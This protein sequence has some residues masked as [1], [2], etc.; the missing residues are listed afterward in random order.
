MDEY[1]NYVDKESNP[2]I[3][4]QARPIENSWG[5]L[6]QKVYEGGWQGS[7]GQVLIDRIKLKLKKI[8]LNFLQSLMKGVKAKLRFITD[9]GVFSYKKNL[10]FI[11]K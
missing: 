3:G 8:D 5:H 1:G 6:A 10:I 2:P 9:D 11:Q 7:K 4:P